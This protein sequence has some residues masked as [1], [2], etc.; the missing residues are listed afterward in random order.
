MW[1]MCFVMKAFCD[2]GGG[3]GKRQSQ[4]E[5]Q[6]LRNFCAVNLRQFVCRETVGIVTVCCLHVGN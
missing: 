1:L 6:K 5:L 2:G 3:R 4:L